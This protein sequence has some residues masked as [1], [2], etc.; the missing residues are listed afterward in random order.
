VR[1]SRTFGAIASA[2]ALLLMLMPAAAQELRKVTIG[3]S[4]SSIALSGARIAQELG[5]FKKHGLDVSISTLDSASAATS[6][7]IGGSID[8]ACVNP[9]DVVLANSRGQSLVVVRS[10]YTGFPAVVVVSKAAAD[11]SGVSP[12][13]P[14]AQRLKALDGLLIATPSATS[15]YTV[16]LKGAAAAEGAQVRFTHMAIPAMVTALQTGA[17]QGYVGSSPFYG[18]S[19]LNGS[20][21]VWINGPQDEI[22]VKFS[23]L[24]SVTLISTRSFVAA[25]ADTVRRVDAAFDDLGKIVVD[26]PAE[27]RA[28]MAKT[29]P[30]ID[31]KSLDIILAA[32]LKSFNGRKLTTED[33]ARTI[34]FVK[35]MGTSLP[36]NLD[37]ST[38]RVP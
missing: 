5:L 11:K 16:S 4:S 6:A 10:L 27:F 23:L 22:P 12:T 25:N 18:T 21:I 26:R 32:E 34:D 15:S 19:V 37:P 36:D 14:V 33:M 35:M 29:Y 13:A 1:Q 9:T 31:A 28:A 17:I 8:F 30:D 3:L 24:N 2:A 20:G 38:M 7:L